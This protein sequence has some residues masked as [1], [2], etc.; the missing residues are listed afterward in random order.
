VLGINGS[1]GETEW[2]HVT[3][4]TSVWALEQLDDVTGDMI[5]DVIAGDFSGQIYYIDPVS[6]VPFDN[7]AING[8]LILRFE[9]LE[10]VNEDGYSDVLVAHSGTNGIVLDGY[11]GSSVWFQPLADKSWC[12]SATNDLDGD[13]I[14]DVLIGTLFSDNYAYFMSGAN[15]DE[16]ESVNYGEAIDAISSIPDIVGDGSREMVVG[17]RYGKVYCYS[18]GFDGVTAVPE[19]IATHGKGEVST[20]PNPYKNGFQVSFNLETSSFVSVKIY[21]PSGI[22]I[23]VIYEGNMDKGPHNL[24]YNASGESRG[25]YFIKVTTDN[26]TAGGKVSKI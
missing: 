2:T 13:A 12:V 17:G 24:Y 15:G 23:D 26:W 22:L 10:D 3:T 21:N 18:G 25:V 6:G 5:K 20:Y 19:K 7:A 9:M 16:I 14:N 4:S 11:N 1:T 8:E